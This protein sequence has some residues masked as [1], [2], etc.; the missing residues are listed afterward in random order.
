MLPNDPV[1]NAI[2]S[3]LHLTIAILDGDGV[4]VDVNDAWTRFA[5]ENG[6]SPL[7]V[8]VNYFDVCRRAAPSC[9]DARKALDGML[10]VCRGSI[11]RFQF[12]YRCDSPA[13]P[14]WFVMTVLPRPRPQPGVIVVHSD[15]TEMQQAEARYGELL[16]AVRAVIWRAQA[17]GFETTFAS[18]QAYDILGFP[19]A[20][21]VRRPDLWRRQIHPDDRDRVLALS[22]TAVREGRNHAFEYR[23]L[24]RDGRVVWLRNIVNVIVEDGAVREL[25]GVSV[26]I[27]DLKEAQGA[28]DEFARA[29][30]NA[31]EKER[32]AIARD[33]H[34]DLGSSVTLLALKLSA[35]GQRVATLPEPRADVDELASLTVKIANDIQRVSHGLHPASLNLL[36]LGAALRQLCTEFGGHQRIALRCDVENLSVNLDTEIAVCLFRVAQEALRNVMKHSG[37]AHAAV[38]LFSETGSVHL[39]I[40]DDGVGFDQAAAKGRGGLGLASMDERV[41]LVRGTFSVSST[42]GEGTRVDV[43]VPVA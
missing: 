31:Y 34:D 3:S 29:L 43:I 28:R 32:A 15:N 14:R 19:A 2:F 1:S 17:P 30:L 4:I 36:G 6:G 37:A 38:R 24:A 11:P 40:S 21:W 23:I 42:P 22:S 20:E 7:S 35:L 18:K 41:R 13:A 33:L 8:G 25:V 39:Q 27:T 5:R 12:P 10:S 16:D 26:D 9:A